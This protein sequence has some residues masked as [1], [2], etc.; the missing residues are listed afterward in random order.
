MNI[1]SVPHNR[2][3]RLKLIKD[4][5]Y[6]R[7]HLRQSLLEMTE[8]EDVN[9]IFKNRKDHYSIEDLEINLQKLPP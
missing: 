2:M 5:K 8:F 6:G 3:G 4:L 1:P 7:V 9:K